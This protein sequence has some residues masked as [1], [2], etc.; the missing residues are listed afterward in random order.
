MRIRFGCGKSIRAARAH[1][2]TTYRGLHSQGRVTSLM[3][4]TSK[5]PGGGIPLR[6]R[7][8][9]R[10]ACSSSPKPLPKSIYENIASVPASTA[11]KTGD[12]DDCGEFRLRK[13]FIGM[14]PKDQNSR[15]AANSL[16]GGQQQRL[17]IARR[18]RSNRR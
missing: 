6:V 7:P 16:S 12:M 3:A 10:Y 8:S 4:R 14:K 1:R 13:A 17:C 15:K 9:D 5:R 18:L 11:F 2:I